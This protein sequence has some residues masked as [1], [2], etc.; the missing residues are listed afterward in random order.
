MQRV[1]P[2]SAPSTDTFRNLPEISAENAF[3]PL[4]D[5]SVTNFFHMRLF[6]KLISFF[7]YVRVYC[8]AEIALSINFQKSD[9]NK[10]SISLTFDLT[11]YHKH[12][13]RL[14]CHLFIW[15]TPLPTVLIR[16]PLFVTIATLAELDL[17]VRQTSYIP[18]TGA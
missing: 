8:M 14:A 2:Q 12:L 15:V 11:K 13:F 5:S 9:E 18:E 10:H 16:L 1:G 6:C 4:A 17:K 3:L 7:L